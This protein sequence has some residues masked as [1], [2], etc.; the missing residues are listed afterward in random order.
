MLI[1]FGL[2]YLPQCTGS[3]ILLNYTTPFFAEAGSSMT[4]LQ[5]SILICIV[6]LVANGITTVFIERW[7]RKVIFVV[8]C[9]GSGLGMIVLALHRLYKDD[10]PSTYDFVPM[11]GL[12]FVI[13]IA[14]IGLLP[15]AYII[16]IDILPP[17]VYIFLLRFKKVFFSVVIIE[18]LRIDFRFAT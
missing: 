9:V 17:K 4:P 14:S 7:G 15:C 16:T 11:Y 2:V 6:Q 3:Y 13:F 5:S 1:S 8:S 10:L 12:S 18:E